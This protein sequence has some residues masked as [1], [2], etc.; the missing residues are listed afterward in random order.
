MKRKYFKSDA[1]CICLARV[2]NNLHAHRFYGVLSYLSLV[3]NNR[4]GQYDDEYDDVI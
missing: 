2:Y 3:L 4:S 1:I